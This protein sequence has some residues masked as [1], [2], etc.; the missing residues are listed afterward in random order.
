ME[1][2]FNFEIDDR[3]VTPF[4][5]PGIVEMLGFDDGGKKYFVKTKTESSWFKEK[6]LE[7]DD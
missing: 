3:V 7:K 1:V 6:D 5:K 4:G 2:K